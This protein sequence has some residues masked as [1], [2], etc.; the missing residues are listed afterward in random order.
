MSAK[1][2]YQK[3]GIPFTSLKEDI[4]AGIVVFLVALPLCMGIALASG[5]PVFSGLIAGCVGGL[6][7]SV[8]STS[9]T[10][11]SGPAA[12]LVVIVLNA[13][14]E[15]GT[16]EAFL[17]AVTISGVLQVILGFLRAGTIGNYFPTSVIKGMLA[18]I[19]LILIIKEIPHAIGY[20]SDFMGD[21]SFFQQD[22]EN[23]F[24]AIISAIKA[25]NVGA[26]IITV[27]SLLILTN[28]D[29]IK[30]PIKKVIPGALVVVI[31]GVALNLFFGAFV[32]EFYL[33]SAHLVSIPSAAEKGGFV[34][35]FTS[36]DFSLFGSFSV[37]KVA[38]TLAIVASLETLLNVEA[39]DKLDPYKRRTS[40]NQE[41]KAQGIG[42]FISGL[43]GGLPVTAVIVRGAANVSSGSKTKASAFFHGVFLFVAVLS[44]PGLLSM[45][46][47]ASLAAILLVIGYKLT[48]IPLYKEMF[49]AGRDQ[50]IPFIVTVL[51]I[52]FTDLLIG[53][54][55]G[56]IVAIFFILRVNMK[57]T[58]SYDEKRYVEGEPIRLILSDEVTFLNK[59]SMRLTLDH[60]PPGSK[61]IIDGT[62]SVFIHYD[63]LEII[64]DFE[65]NAHHRDIEVELVNI[66]KTYTK[67]T[68]G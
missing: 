60:M 6:I 39:V 38:I 42:N 63:V 50:F 9:Q 29:K 55:I 62:K 56:M 26:I 34:N 67:A 33:T 17:L 4:P 64:R 1:N 51:A 7:V 49:K 46:P 68:F 52:M 10:S 18:A 8:F 15:L 37:Y 22:G 65:S 20:D 44:V 14:E 3:Y 21:D 47:Y 57:N 19:G 45:I 61:V 11:V 35:L 27:I 48:R 28:W 53:V 59:A 2:L 25:L 32:P 43:I 16:F 12:G 5:V 36:P 41:L 23:S 40:S 13:L 58:Y 24:T 66:Q 54:I 31:L 30:H